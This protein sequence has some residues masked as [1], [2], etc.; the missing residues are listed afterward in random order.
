[1]Y[2]MTMASNFFIRATSAAFGQDIAFPYGNRWRWQ[3]Q[4]RPPVTFPS[5]Y[6]HFHFIGKCHRLRGAKLRESEM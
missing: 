4:N 3:F 5:S 1:M 2:S 6:I